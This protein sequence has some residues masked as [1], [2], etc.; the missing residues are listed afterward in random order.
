M[1]DTDATSPPDPG[2]TAPDTPDA[3]DAQTLSAAAR[4]PS[5]AQDYN[6]MPYQSVAYPASSPDRI[7]AVAHLFG[8]TP[9]DPAR[10]RVLELGCASGG[11]ILPFAQRF[12][13]ARLL[14]IDL[15]EGQVATG[16]RRIAALGLDNIEIRH[17][18]I[19]EV[20]L[21]AAA[22]DYLVVH[23]V[24]SW[25][26]EHAQEAVFAIAQRCL[27]PGGLAYISYNTFPGWNMRK[28]VRDLTT[29]HAGSGGTP[30]FRVARARWLLD[31]LGAMPERGVYSQML[32][33]EAELNARQPD[34]Y[35]LGEFLADHNRPVYFHEFIA[36]AQK[37]DLAYLSEADVAAS[38]PE[39]LGAE[40]AR[41]VRKIAG[42]NGMALEQYM[43]FF[44]GRQFRRSILTK[45]DPEKPLARKLAL[46]R[47]AEL[48]LRS[49][50]RR[51]PEALPGI[52]RR[53][54]FR[55]QKRDVSEAEEALFEALA[56]AAPS[57]MPVSALIRA[58]LAKVEAAGEKEIAALLTALFR[59]AF[60][61]GFDLTFLPYK[62]G[63]ASDAKP[64]VSD[65]V[66]LEAASGQSWLSAPRHEPVSL[67][68]DSLV[69]LVPFVD[70]TRSKQELTDFLTAQIA[71]GGLTQQG[72]VVGEDLSPA[73]RAALAERIITALLDRLEITG[74]LEPPA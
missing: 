65:L 46:S 28:T 12:P 54:T 61:G 40:T 21:P 8:L 1:T 59:M 62:A 26:P 11:N 73:E 60:S 19:A 70:G 69:S 34:S 57:S 14:G 39:T 7:A 55:D 52:E 29:Y 5:T 32:K 9:P 58:V 24:W 2:P 71:S 31:T 36:R 44:I 68:A 66:R 48:H 63:R 47:L 49:S 23:G 42:D 35:I 13:E 41:V 18:D 56:A 16:Q 43:D 4:S 25:I 53:W 64:R 67:G 15:S 33:Q 20:D 38:I 30:E 50:W 74:L 51:D 37:E 27:A 6:D 17:G 22:F 3:P 45:P 72:K 10:A